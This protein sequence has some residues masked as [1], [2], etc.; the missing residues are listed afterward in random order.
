MQGGILAGRVAIIT[1]GGGGIGSATAQR[2]AQSGA[3]V[4]VADL[5]AQAARDV[6]DKLKAEGLIAEAFTID[7]AAEEQIKELVVK[8]IEAF[9]RIDILHNNAVLTAPDIYGQDKTLVDM[10]AENWDKIFA[11]NTRGPMLLSKYVVPHMID[12]KSG[13]VIVNMSSGAS[14]RGQPDMLTAYGSSKGAI[15][16]LTLYIAAQYGAYNIRCNAL[17]CEV[18]LTKG[19]RALFAPEFV[20]KLEDETPLRR[21]SAP[22]DVA[23]MVHFLAS[24]EARQLTGRLIRL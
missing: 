19:L 2:L 3:A 24:D 9:G 4:A 10:T 12:Q 23:A 15:N 21:A 6:A 1:G 17:V 18:V 8:T 20:K 14:E 13:G 5:N 11:V 22:E 16:S 7:M